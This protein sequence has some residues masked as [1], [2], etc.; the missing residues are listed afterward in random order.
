MLCSISDQRTALQHVAFKP[1]ESLSE[2][3]VAVQMQGGCVSV[4]VAAI[5]TVQAPAICHCQKLSRAG[6]QSPH[7]YMGFGAIHEFRFRGCPL[8]ALRVFPK[9]LLGFSLKSLRVLLKVLTG[10][11]SRS[12]RRPP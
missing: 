3:S 8:R 12:L 7:G 9:G 4:H 6:V 1:V 5:A 10:P 11:P 2:S